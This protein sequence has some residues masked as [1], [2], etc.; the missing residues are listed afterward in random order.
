MYLPYKTKKLNLSLDVQLLRNDLKKVPDNWWLANYFHD[1]GNAVVP[2]V[3]QYGTLKNAD[4]TDNH[5]LLG[6]YAVTEH[7]Q[8]LPYIRE[9]IHSL[10]DE[11]P[12]TRLMRIDGGEKV[13][14][15]Q[16]RNP[17]W[18][19]RAR[20]H[21]PIVTNPRVTFHV[22]SDSPSMREADHHAVHM[23]EG[24]AWVFNN[25]YYHA[26]SNDSGEPRIHLVVDLR[27]TGWI[28]DMMFGDCTP[29]Q[30]ADC[31]R[32]EYPPYQVDEA[33]LQ[34]MTG[35]RPDAGIAAWNAIVTESAK[36]ATE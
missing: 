15:H 29:E 9:I 19:N 18:R 4:G 2:L 11:P 27:P 13:K 31:D 6:P 36:Q 1:T 3:S 16:D 32:F 23:G 24:E 17:V 28:W 30:I 34:W 33:S 12:R 25:W 10:S 21:I 22:W 26:V 14:P 8:A 7:L 5:S 35:G 20:L